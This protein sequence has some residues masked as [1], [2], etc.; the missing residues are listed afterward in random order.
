[1]STRGRMTE[2]LQVTLA[3]RAAEEVAF[4]SPTTYSLEDIEVQ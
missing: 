4:G 1:M 3:G 2:R